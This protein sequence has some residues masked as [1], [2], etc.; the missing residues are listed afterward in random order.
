MEDISTGAAGK[1]L[2]TWAAIGTTLLAG[3]LPAAV[4]WGA[5][6]KGQTAQAETI[7][8][9]AERVE[10]MDVRLR[11]NETQAAVVISRLEDLKASVDD[12]NRKL[13]RLP[14]R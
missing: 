14:V 10:S 12:T 1:S 13:D 9:V 7:S 2:S 8:H 5:L 11:M 6:S 4:A 3:I